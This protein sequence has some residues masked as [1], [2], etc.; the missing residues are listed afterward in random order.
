MREVAYRSMGRHPDGGERWVY[1]DDKAAAEKY[2]DDT[3]RDIYALF[4]AEEDDLDGS[5]PNDIVLTV[6]RRIH[7]AVDT[8]AAMLIV[9][10]AKDE[11][12]FMLSK[13]GEIWDALNANAALIK[14]VGEEVAERRKERGEE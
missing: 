8:L 2:R 14:R 4:L 13:S 5:T 9:K 10:T 3:G 1:F 7:R 6:A 12:P 11:Q